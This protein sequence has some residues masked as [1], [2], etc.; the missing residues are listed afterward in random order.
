MEKIIVEFGT[1]EYDETIKL[2]TEILRKPLGLEFTEEQLSKE[3]DD[4]H[5]AI[6][7]TDNSIIGCLILTK[8]DDRTVKM[9][10]VAIAY[11]HQ[12]KGVG[13]ELVAF[14]ETYAMHIGYQKIELNARDT[15]VP[16]YLAL[17]YKIDGDEFFEVGIAHK[18]MFKHLKHMP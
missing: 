11:T 16:F 9:R 17:D 12:G 6:L 18:F 5:L 7:D 10:Q 15:A 2:R 1:P 3:Y 4:A 8:K 14:S 13:K